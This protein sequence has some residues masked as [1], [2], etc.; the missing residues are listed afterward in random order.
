MHLMLEEN[1]V[2]AVPAAGVPVIS[3]ARSANEVMSRT[4]RCLLDSLAHA[5]RTLAT[6]LRLR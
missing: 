2:L 5:V 4:S 1:L 6:R 3:V